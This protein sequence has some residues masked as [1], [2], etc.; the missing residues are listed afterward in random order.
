MSDPLLSPPSNVT[1]EREILGA[2]IRDPEARDILATHLREHH[3]YS[4]PH[5]A[6]FDAIITAYNDDRSI[7]ASLLARNFSRTAQGLPDNT[8]SI[9]FIAAVV[10]DACVT[11]GMLDR[12]TDIKA[13]Y[14]AREIHRT[15]Q[16]LS[17][18]ALETEGDPRQVETALSEATESLAS[19]TDDMVATPWSTLD[20][21]FTEASSEDATAHHFT[22]GLKDLDKKLL[23]GFRPGQYVTVAGRPGQGKSTLAL[24][25]ARHASIVERVPGL[26]LSLEMNARE[27]G[28]RIISAEAH[29]DQARLTR[30]ELANNEYAR[31]QGAMQKAHGAPFLFDTPE[32]HWPSIRALIV[33]AARR[34]GIKWFVI[35]YVQLIESDGHPDS[36]S[37]EQTV[38]RIS[39][40]IKSLALSLGITAIVVAQLNR[41]PES[42]QG[43]RPM[44]SDLRESGQL[45]QDS[46][47]VV[48]IHQ[49]QAYDPNTA[50]VGEADLDIGKHRGGPTGTVTVAALLHYSKFGDMAH[51]DFG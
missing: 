23:G 10:N 26:F 4:L 3:F 20:Q 15:A 12:I 9:S 31:V 29:V 17:T 16:T 50:R 21:V 37:R 46:D 14:D 1:F 47:I 36:S 2:A 51:G 38:S 7:D 33:S 19:L 41:G 45:E 18:M 39:R 13:C 42:R 40:G 30:R 6:L 5:K 35:D 28:T 11:A 43:G 8:D 27:V 22:S 49:E 32:P 44:V 25:I 34:H 24:D 48:L